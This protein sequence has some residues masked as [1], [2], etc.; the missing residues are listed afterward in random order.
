MNLDQ[1]SQSAPDGAMVPF[2]QQVMNVAQDTNTVWNVM[3]D[4]RLPAGATALKACGSGFEIL[5]V[6]SMTAGPG[7]CEAIVTAA[8]FCGGPAVLKLPV[9]IAVQLRTHVLSLVR[10]SN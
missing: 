4:S 5:L 1:N 3:R 9:E 6:A 8:D 7:Y 2:L 10:S